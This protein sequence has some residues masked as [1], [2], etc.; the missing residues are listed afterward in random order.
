MNGSIKAV[1]TTLAV[2]DTSS[3]TATDSTKS[4]VERIYGYTRIE[5]NRPAKIYAKDDLVDFDV[6]VQNIGGDDV[7]TITA[8]RDIV[9]S[10]VGGSA[11]DLYTAPSGVAVGKA[12]RR[13]LGGPGIQV[14]GAGFLMVEAGRD[15]GPFL[16]LSRDT[17]ALTPAQRGIA[18]LANASDWPVGNRY[19]PQASSGT[20]NLLLLG[21]ASKTPK[22]RNALLASTG[23][24]LIVRFGV[25]NGTDDEA[26][27]RTYVDPA[28]AG[29]VPHNYV[30]DIEGFLAALGIP[31]NGMA[32]ARNKFQNLETVFQQMGK[33]PRLAEAL[34]RE[35][36]SLE[37][38]LVRIGVPFD[39]AADAWDK[40]RNLADH[41]QQQGKDPR[42][43]KD[44]QRAFVDQVFMAELKAVGEAQASTSGQ[45]QRGYQMVNTLFPATLGY[46][47]NALGGTS[48]AATLVRTGD[49][50][51]HHATIQTRLGGNISIF[52]PGGSIRVGALALEPNANLKLNDVGILTLGGGS[53]STF[54]DG[55]VLVNQSRVMTQQGGD[56]L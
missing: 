51:M 48:G 9:Y 12:A 50:D 42:L 31:T 19:V 41:L 53:I 1:A 28:N 37:A 32:D 44:L 14:A 40:F 56:I 34:K 6:I 11:N 43:A 18:S 30:G 38:F 2:V 25:A 52:G 29:L 45:Y 3:V 55:S 4:N 7:S 26:V 10:Y 24:D 54:T 16:P 23:A 17:K 20:Y 35:Y 47:A 36:V 13:I 15:L 21:S 8:G 46:S 33:D 22:K 49:L 39:S 5:I 27:L